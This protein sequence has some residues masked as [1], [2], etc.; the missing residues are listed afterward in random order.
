MKKGKLFFCPSSH[1]PFLIPATPDINWGSGPSWI[2]SWI[3]QSDAFM[4]VDPDPTDPNYL[5]LAKYHNWNR[6]MLVLCDEKLGMIDFFGNVFWDIT[7]RPVGHEHY[8]N[9]AEMLRNW[10]CRRGSTSKRL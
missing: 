8:E 2:Q 4:I 9:N 6:P 5:K 10:K 1:M 7:P 3:R